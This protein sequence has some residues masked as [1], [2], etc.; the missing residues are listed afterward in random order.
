M[1][2]PEDDERPAEHGRPG[3]LAALLAPRLVDQRS[4]GPRAEREHDD[5]V[6]QADVGAAERQRVGQRLD[7]RER[8]RER[9]HVE[10]DP[11]LPEQEGGAEGDQGDEGE[12]DARR[13]VPSGR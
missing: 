3:H 4:E 6:L 8:Q 2:Q 9:E 11:P 1:K 5:Q 7:A 10:R 13:S 12:G